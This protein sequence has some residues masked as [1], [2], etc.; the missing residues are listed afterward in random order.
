M[1]ALGLGLGVLWELLVELLQ[2]FLHMP[3]P[4]VTLRDELWGEGQAGWRGFAWYVPA[5]SDL[6]STFNRLFLPGIFNLV[7]YP[8]PTS[9][10]SCCFQN[11][12]NLKYASGIQVY[13]LNT[14]AFQ[15]NIEACQFYSAAATV[16]FLHAKVNLAME[17]K[18]AVFCQRFVNDSRRERSE[19]QGEIW[20]MQLQG[21][22][23]KLKT[24]SFKVAFLPLSGNLH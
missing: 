4:A 16:G 18:T 13:A 19:V 11:G 7:S 5:V 6:L 14:S 1:A 10:V 8:K 3:G 20:Q 22:N 12:I 24:W 17:A 15:E 9:F 21:W 23:P 2:P